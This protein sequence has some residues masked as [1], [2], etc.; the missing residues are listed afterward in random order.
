LFR[1]TPLLLPATAESAKPLPL[2]A[3]GEGEGGTAN[4]VTVWLRAGGEV[5]LCLRGEK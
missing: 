4:H 5:V 1:P 2:Q 3:G